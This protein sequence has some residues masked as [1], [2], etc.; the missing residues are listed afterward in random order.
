MD[1]CNIF[2]AEELDFVIN[3]VVHSIF[4]FQ[5]MGVAYYWIVVGGSDLSEGSTLL[6]RGG[7]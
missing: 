4:V 3:R 1:G 5:I 2:L 7:F 6:G